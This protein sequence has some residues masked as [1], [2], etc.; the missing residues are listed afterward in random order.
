LNV[1]FFKRYKGIYYPI[2]GANLEQMNLCLRFHVS[3][4]FGK[5]SFEPSLYHASSSPTLNLSVCHL[6]VFPTKLSAHLMSLR[7]LILAYNNLN[8]LPE[9]ISNLSFL[10]HLNLRFNHLSNLS[11]WIGNLSS[12]QK[13][14][15][16]PNHFSD[17]IAI[18][19]LQLLPNL[20]T[21]NV[22]CFGQNIV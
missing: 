12:L 6:R 5:I 2:L 16:F 10:Q 15:L 22:S 11:S 19:I 1:H 21:D 17:F 9:W 7:Y 14:D 20:H 4:P 13:L 8:T 3:A 18:F